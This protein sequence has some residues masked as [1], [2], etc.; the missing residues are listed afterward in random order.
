MAN[1][2]HSGWRQEAGAS[3][4][5]AGLDLHLTEVSDAVTANVTKGPSS[6]DASSLNAYLATLGQQRERLVAIVARQGRG[7]LRRVRF[8]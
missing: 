3:A 6:R 8:G 1:W 4:Q 7:G 2:I 5:L